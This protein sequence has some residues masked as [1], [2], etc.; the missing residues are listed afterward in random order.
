M[1]SLNMLILLVALSA[2]E[3]FSLVTTERRDMGGFSV[4]PQIE[5]SAREQAGIEIWTIHG[6]GLEAVYFAEGI[7][8]GDPFF[9]LKLGE[10]DN[11][12]PRFRSAM[13]ANEAMEFIVD[14]ISIS[15]AGGVRATA[16]RPFAFGSY[17]GFRFDL[18]YRTA[19]GLEGRGRAVGAI[20][21]DKLYLLL[22][23]AAAEH[24]FEFYASPVE[25]MIE[26]LK[27]P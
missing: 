2:C 16:L 3:T 8:D 17:P 21:D 19:D 1:R 10:S 23:L 6:S 12:L 22:Y 7:A 5:W 26:S 24:Y 14:T 11:Q 27:T 15:G 13:T 20:I 18:D 25:R 4:E 9:E